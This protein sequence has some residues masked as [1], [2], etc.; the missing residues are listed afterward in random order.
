MES[1]ISNDWRNHG[2]AGQQPILSGQ[3]HRVEHP[4][5]RLQIDRQQLQDDNYTSSRP[6]ERV[7]AIAS[8]TARQSGLLVEA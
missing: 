6:D 3:M 1:A 2:E 8:M 7:A 5:Q 4:R